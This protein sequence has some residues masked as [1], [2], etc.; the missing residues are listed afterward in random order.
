MYKVTSP[1]RS[2]IHYLQN[3]VAFL[4]TSSARIRLSLERPAYELLDTDMGNFPV[5]FINDFL[6]ISVTF[7]FWI[8]FIWSWANGQFLSSLAGNGET[9]PRP[10]GQLNPLVTAPTSTIHSVRTA[11]GKQFHVTLKIVSKFVDMHLLIQIFGALLFKLWQN[12][13]HRAR[14]VVHVCRAPDGLSRSYNLGR[15]DIHSAAYQIVQ[16]VSLEPRIYDP[17]RT[18]TRRRFSRCRSCGAEPLH[19]TLTC[20]KALPHVESPPHVLSD[21]SA[22]ISRRKSRVP[23]AQTEDLF[24][25]YTFETPVSGNT[26]GPLS[27]SSANSGTGEDIA[28]RVWCLKAINQR[29]LNAAAA[30]R[31]HLQ[32][33]YEQLLRKRQVRLTL[34]ATQLFR[35]AETKMPSTLEDGYK[36]DRIWQLRQAS[37]SIFEQIYDPLCK[38]L[39]FSGQQHLFQPQSIRE[40]ITLYL[41][42]KMSAEAFLSPYFQSKPKLVRNPQERTLTQEIQRS[43]TVPTVASG[44]SVNSRCFSCKPRCASAP[45]KAQGDNTNDS[46]KRRF[47]CCSKPKNN[48]YSYQTWR[49]RLHNSSSSSLIFHGL[50]FELLRADVTLM[51]TVYRLPVL[52]LS[53]TQAI[54]LWSTSL[55]RNVSM[56]A[57][58][59][60][61]Y[62]ESSENFMEIRI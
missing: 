10:F 37:Q 25:I 11:H 32:N 9:Q 38:Y 48:Y 35:S 56:P 19:S 55:P 8:Y 52:Q 31:N 14:Y 24:K 21:I 43:P 13:S 61:T 62:V 26:K 53:P 27:H 22:P 34:L 42:C 47:I 39:R 12:A 50:R 44:T 41:I 45:E 49:L 17:L 6:M 2:N 54:P 60:D 51:C 58:T 30:E 28:T 29:Q 5:Y 40:R 46:E 33:E 15:I 57:S 16:Y 20:T 4:K 23:R 18:K 59:V 1:V 7:I 3:P 36:S